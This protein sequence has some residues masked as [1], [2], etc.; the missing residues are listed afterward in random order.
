MFDSFTIVCLLFWFVVFFFVIGPLLVWYTGEKDK[1][2]PQT[3]P[4]HR[5]PYTS[6]TQESIGNK[7]ME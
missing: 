2:T 3:S 6:F 7:L 5:A 1:G 4:Q